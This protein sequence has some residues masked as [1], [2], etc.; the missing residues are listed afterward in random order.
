MKPKARVSDIVVQE[1]EKEVLVYDTKVNKAYCLNETSSLVWQLANGN[2]SVAE[3]SDILSEEL[4]VPVPAELVWMALDGL[5]N[6][7]LL[8]E[9][10]ELQGLNRRQAIQK[11]GLAASAVALPLIASVF[12]PSPAMAASCFI[13]CLGR[14]G[15]VLDNC[16]APTN[17]GGCPPPLVCNFAN[18]C[19]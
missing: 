2:N 15:T 17:C 10:F 16:G 19:V 12:V 14:C 9:S 6:D 18:F 1:L 4:Q 3:I 13:S 8:E 11:L 5:K 7:G